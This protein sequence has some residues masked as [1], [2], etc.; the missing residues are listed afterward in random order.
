MATLP[1]EHG[2]WTHWEREHIGRLEAV[3][4]CTNDWTLESGK[5]DDGDPWCIVHDERD[6]T[7]LIHIAR[8]DRRYLVAWPQRN[9]SASMATIEAAIDFALREMAHLAGSRQRVSQG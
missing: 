5:S 6:H 9:W 2:D 1:P 4:R 7:V 8:I 3:C